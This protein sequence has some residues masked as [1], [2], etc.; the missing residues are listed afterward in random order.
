MVR[1]L[2]VVLPLIDWL[3]EPLKVTVWLPGA[4]VTPLLVQLPAR[5][6][7]PAAV[8]VPEPPRVR[9]PYVA[10]ATVWLVPA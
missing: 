8:L 5:L 4:K 9:W 3:V 6:M 7:L 1:L 2:K 10:A